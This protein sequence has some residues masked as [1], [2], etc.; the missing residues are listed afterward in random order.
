MQELF[1]MDRVP[2]MYTSQDKHQYPWPAESFRTTTQQQCEVS[3]CH[4][5]HK[6]LVSA[7]KRS[8]KKKSICHL[9]LLLYSAKEIHLKVVSFDRRSH[10]KSI[11]QR[12]YKDELTLRV[13]IWFNREQTKKKVLL[14]SDSL[15]QIHFP[16]NLKPSK[17]KLSHYITGS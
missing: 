8:F 1:R 16:E 13:V 12:R 9:L 11:L 2:T 14:N 15:V 3:P 5:S 7:F 10:F 6:S 17:F 4:S